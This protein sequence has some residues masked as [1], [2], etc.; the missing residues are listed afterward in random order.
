MAEPTCHYCDRP[1][2]EECP[3]CGRLYCHEH[4][5]D[6]CLRCLAPESA[7]P[8]ATVYRG[9]LVALAIASVVALFLILSPPQSKSTASQAHTIATNTP[10]SNPTATPTPQGQRTPSATATQRANGSA[11]AA[12]SANASN[13]ERT[14]TV[15]DGDTLSG[16][17][18]ANG[19]SLEALQAANPGVT[20]E[21]L[22]IGA[23]LKLP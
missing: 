22:D 11:T 8:G 5:E 20:A 15:K 10:S 14:Y 18:E 1:A 23:V 6:V 4:G 3:A 19:V 12:P 13:G 2:A 16:I 7:T 17:A 21:T 9:S